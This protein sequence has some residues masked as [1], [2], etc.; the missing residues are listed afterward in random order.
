ME[1]VKALATDACR[2][3]NHLRSGTI[4]PVSDSVALAR[5]LERG[6]GREIARALGLAPGQSVRLVKPPFGRAPHTFL[7]QADG[8]VMGVLHAVRSHRSLERLR[9]GR[10]Q[11][12]EQGVPV[13]R[14][15]WSDESRWARL[16]RG[17]YL[18]VESYID[19][20]PLA[21]V[22]DR[23]EALDALARTLARLH[24]RER[25]GWGGLRTGRSTGYGRFR[26]KEITSTLKQ[27]VRLKALTRPESQRIER[28]FAGWKERL[29]G[30][31]CFQL[32]HDDLHLNNILVGRD[33]TP[34]LIDL[35]CL[36]YDRRE[37]D[38]ARAVTQLFDFDAHVT[39][40]FLDLY[41]RE[42]VEPDRKLLQFETA[43]RGLRYWANLWERAERAG[44]G[45]A[46]SDLRAG[47]LEWRRRAS[48]YIS[49][50]DG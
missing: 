42:A 13:A 36:R 35:R 24:G 12:Q 34:H 19:G 8:S 10:E 23:R 46:G 41:A 17:T 43:A 37:R 20:T 48:E 25:R 14:L 1:Q 40:R 49:S 22:A 21:E 30:L 7:V 31:S 26:M 15:M 3:T 2:L 39:S 16:R 27:M 29:D 4:P 38:L 11:L 45:S 32:I 50:L 33:G 6:A 18:V 44:P 5:R 9:M 28:S 47:S